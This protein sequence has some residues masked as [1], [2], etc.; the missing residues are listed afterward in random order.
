MFALL[1]HIDAEIADVE[2]LI[3]FK[4]DIIISGLL[5]GADTSDDEE[6]VRELNKAL[7]LKKG[8]RRSLVA[9]LP[10]GRSAKAAPDGCVALRSGT[11]HDW[12]FDLRVLRARPVH[13]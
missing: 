9:E 8:A 10:F 1:T 2:G 7:Q 3:S 4:N 11:K 6:Q 13:R 5:R 12:E